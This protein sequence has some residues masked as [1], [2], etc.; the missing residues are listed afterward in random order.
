MEMCRF[1]RQKKFC[2]F[3]IVRTILVVVIP[4]FKG[5]AKQNFIDNN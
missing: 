1:A 4:V 5:E 2:L 3:A